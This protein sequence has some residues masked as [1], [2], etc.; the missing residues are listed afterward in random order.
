MENHNFELVHTTGLLETKIQV[1]DSDIDYFKDNT[2]KL[3]RDVEVYQWFETEV[4]EGE[5]KIYSHDKKWTNQKINQS[6]F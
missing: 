3:R 1:G 4:T 6:Q 5:Q 2:V